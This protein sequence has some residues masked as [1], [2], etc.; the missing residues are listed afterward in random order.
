MRL[1]A[2]LLVSVVLAVVLAGSF[3]HLATARI[4]PGTGAPPLATI[5]DRVQ[6]AYNYILRL[7]RSFGGILAGYGVVSSYPAVPVSVYDPYY[8][9]W[10]PGLKLYQG[11]GYRLEADVSSLGVVAAS[12]YTEYKFVI[13]L[14]YVVVTTSGTYTETK[15]KIYVTEHREP[16]NDYVVLTVADSVIDGHGAEIYLAGRYVGTVVNGAYYVVQLADGETLPSMRT[17]FR[18]EDVFGSMVFKALGSTALSDVD[19]L[20]DTIQDDILGFHDFDIYS[21]MLSGIGDTGYVGEPAPEHFYDGVWW[22]GV[23]G[24]DIIWDWFASYNLVAGPY[25]VYPYKSKIAAY[26]EET[27]LNGGLAYIMGSSARS[28]PLYFGWW[29]L[30]Y[31]HIGDWNSAIDLWN[32][33]F[34]N[35]W[36]GAGVSACPNPLDP[37]TC[38]S[39]TYSTVR[40]A[41]GL[42]LG[43]ILARHGW[44]SWDIVD[45]M[46]YVLVYH[47]QWGDWGYYTPDKGATVKHIYKPDHRGGFMVAYVKDSSGRFVFAEFRSG[48]LEEISDTVLSATRMDP[49]YGGPIPTNAETTI[50]AMAALMQ[51]AY[52]RYGV[53]PA[54]LLG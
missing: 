14:Q 54:Q 11:T 25:P 29:G 44:I 9:W 39:D 45:E 53:P 3:A 27:G 43:S 42:A 17:A 4:E 6:K 20:S 18:H 13:A 16:G 5:K 35:R 38:I 36:D 51:Y 24:Y 32:Q 50:I 8:G 49:E 22:D 37:A 7:K 41:V 10:V 21:T 33:Y 31:A 30:Y 40:L 28:D 47:L 34:V 23:L 12:T 48:Y 46:A 1:R 26:A 15:A 19:T 2:L 52:G